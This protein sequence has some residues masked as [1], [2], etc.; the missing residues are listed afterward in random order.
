MVFIVTNVSDTVIFRKQR[1]SLLSGSKNRLH[2]SDSTGLFLRNSTE[3][4]K[5][6]LKHEVQFF[7]PV[8]WLFNIPDRVV[9][10]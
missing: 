2:K 4:H 5:N 1:P 7:S 9:S 6:L 10:G 8:Y 3:I